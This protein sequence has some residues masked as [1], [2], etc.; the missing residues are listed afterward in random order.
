ML[1]GII[2]ICQI[3]AKKIALFIMILDVLQF[4]TFRVK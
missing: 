2:P 3:F 4:L 1:W